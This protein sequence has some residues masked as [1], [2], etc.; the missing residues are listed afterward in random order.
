MD[1]AYPDLAAERSVR[2]RSRLLDQSG[3][4]VIAGDLNGTIEIWSQGAEA[5][6]GWRADEVVGRNGIDVLVPPEGR[7][8]ARAN[9]A[10]LFAGGRRV[11]QR[12]LVRKDGTTFFAQATTVVY[13]DDDGEDSGIVHVAID[14]TERVHAERE[15]RGA[16]DYLRAVA[17]SMGEALCT[18]DVDG[19][20]RYINAAAEK[21]LGWTLTELRGRALHDSV[22]FRRPNGEP[23]P[24]EE[25]PLIA[26]ARSGDTVQMD[27]DMFIR[28]DG[29]TFSV[30]YTSAPFESENGTRGL[31][32]VFS[33]I[34][35]RKA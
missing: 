28:R 17:D 18:L 19:R 34:T 11:A 2:R 23:C 25:C 35:E 10:S 24:A 15:L 22:H 3:A 21:A 4:A 7:A 32:V 30:S 8:R 31:V 16:R 6:Y 5:L 1:P 29:S 12:E 9:F 14:I 27:D 20:V 33:D 26:A 13:R